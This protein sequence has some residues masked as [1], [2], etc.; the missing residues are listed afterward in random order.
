TYALPI[1]YGCIDPVKSTITIIYVDH[2]GP[3]IVRG[4]VPETVPHGRIG[5]DPKTDT[6]VFGHRKAYG[7]VVQIGN[8][9]VLLL[10]PVFQSIFRMGD[11]CGISSEPQLGIGS[12]VS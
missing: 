6:H 12:G 10:R 8:G 9:V 1:S 4:L 11:S 5:H 7:Q 3:V 2:F